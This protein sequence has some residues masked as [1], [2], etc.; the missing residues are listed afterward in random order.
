M[1]NAATATVESRTVVRNI[2]IC[3]FVSGALG[4]AYQ[5]L[6]LRKLLLVFGS[7]V[8]AVSTV[9]T[10]FFAGLALG[11]WLF[12]KLIDRRPQEGL[13]W[14]AWIEVAIGAYAFLT[15]FLFHA[16]QQIYVPIY[17][18]SGMSPSVLVGASFVCSMLILL[19]PTILMGG[20]FPVLSRYLIH[21]EGERG[22][23]V[24]HLYGINTLGAMA[25]TLTV[26][27]FGLPMLGLARTLVC[28]GTLNLGIGA[29][30]L[31]FDRHLESLGFGEHRLEKTTPSARAKEKEKETAEGL[32]WI[33]WAFALSG[34]AS[35]A[36]EVT[37]TRALSLVLGSSIY[38][39]CV[40]LATFL[41]GMALGS[42]YARGWLKDKPATIEQVIS[43]ELGLGICGLLSLVVFHVLPDAFVSFW[44]AFGHDFRSLITIQF[45]LCAIAMSIPTLLLG[46]LFPVVTDLLTR[47]FSAFGQRL[48][49]AYAVNT[50]GGI[51]GSF[52][53]GFFLIPL[54]GLP[55]AIVT[56]AFV[57]IGAALL[58]YLK[59]YPGDFARRAAL[60]ATCALGSI[61]LG[62]LL[63]R[64]VWPTQTLSA[65]AYLNPDNYRGI[66]V[67]AGA[68][69]ADLLFYKDSLNA[70]VSVHRKGNAIYLKVGGKTDA[71]NGIDMSTQVMSGHVP[72][73]LH[74]NPQSAL[75]IGLG[76][77]VTLGS[78]SRYPVKLLDCA[79]LDPAVVE[80]A[81]YFHDYN[82]AVHDDPRT[83]MFVADGRNFLLASPDKYDVIIS[84]PSNPWMAGVAT[85]FTKQF[86]ELATK[87][88][89]TGGIMCQWLQLYRIFPEDVKLILRTYHS[90]FPYVTVWSTIP[91][92]LLLIGSM[93]P[94]D[95]DF[96][97]VAKRMAD[98]KIAEALKV[99]KIERPDVFF[100][101]MLFGTPEVEKATADITWNHEDDQPWIE[102]DAPK[103]LYAD[104]TLPINV[105]GIEQFR[106]PL[107]S[108]VKG[109]DP[110]R[111]DAAFHLAMADLWEY[112][113][114]PPKFRKS[115]EDATKAEP[116]NWRAWYRLGV[117][118]MQMQPL[119][120]EGDLRR[121]ADLAPREQL[122]ARA[123]GKLNW[124]QGKS[125]D[126]S[127]WYLTAASLK[128]PDS[129]LAEEIGDFFRHQKDLGWAAE[130][131]RSAISQ[132]GG[133][134]AALVFALAEVLKE[135]G[136]VDE[137]RRAAQYGMSAFPDEAAF[138]QIMGE[139][140]LD[141]GKTQ[142]AAILFDRAMKLK[143]GIPEPRYGL[144][145]VAVVSGAKDLAKH[146]L[147][148]ATRYKPFHQPS[149]ELLDKLNRE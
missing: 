92:D 34:F 20:S 149:L 30:C 25:G 60:S 148:E 73:L 103:A 31:V 2:H 42:L 144:A 102:F 86:Y 108:V 75:V 52:L 128:A 45:A 139:I 109:Y 101:L 119:G 135:L 8:H 93:E 126:A 41:G 136:K 36:Y 116:T 130:F 33:F 123:L 124:L 84:E 38:A 11:S 117:M 89:A 13:K 70:T 96:E 106:V 50:L 5:V 6:W 57:N 104:E 146:L 127:T 133:S 22:S 138:A 21:A 83:R 46:F 125:D 71:S 37:W 49:T 66:S 12:G 113:N 24:A 98:P 10:V 79:E 147:Q 55:W 19:V 107:Q 105:R 68:K 35:I 72:M 120:A 48:G 110:A 111:E 88:L 32:V 59:F 63:V 90:V 141:E 132:D 29:L 4:L 67:S 115:L 76:S 143:P 18:G 78:V 80:G 134:R 51:L 62:T 140:D 121:A 137:A 65:G 23:S 28:A 17:R 91:G 114:E 9:L 44:N 1:S 81:R 82:Y 99:V 61:V 3:Y 40:I 118:K 26:Y 94:L 53:S 16:I 39:F 122:P 74:P 69:E 142:E 47:R 112:R 43:I 131:Y 58:L 77:G 7:T 85:L 129:Q 64:H 27:F 15:P 56:A 95:L 145:K 100:N 14:Y 97:R 54:F 87:R